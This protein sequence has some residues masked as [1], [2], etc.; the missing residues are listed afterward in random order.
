[1]RRTLITLLTAGAGIVAGFLISNHIS[2]A[3][4]CESGISG[5]Q[6]GL[7]RVEVAAA[8]RSR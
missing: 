7:R 8:F 6:A 5:G 2:F 4:G 1:M 3:R